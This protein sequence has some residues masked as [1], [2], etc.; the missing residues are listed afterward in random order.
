LDYLT[1]GFSTVVTFEL[2]PDISFFEK[3][4]T[5]P[6]VT[7]E[8][9]INTTTMYNDTWRT[10]W[11]KSL[12]TAQA[13][14]MN[15]AFATSSYDDSVATTTPDVT[16][17]GVMGMIGVNQRITINF[18]DFTTLEVMGW[19]ED[20]KPRELKEG[21]QPMAELTL[22]ISNLEVIAGTSLVPDH[23]EITPPVYDDTN[24]TFP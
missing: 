12:Q 9:P 11:P 18:P 7:G 6:G 2:G 20:F 19:I 3:E 8:G 13:I 23:F 17:A 14:T 22:H 10:A 5:P 4:V 16:Y 21:E 1:D 15:G 24:Y